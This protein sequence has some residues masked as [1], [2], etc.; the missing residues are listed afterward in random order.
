MLRLFDQ[1]VNI[2]IGPTGGDNP[3]ARFSAAGNKLSRW[4]DGDHDRTV[5]RDPLS[6]QRIGHLGGSHLDPYGA[7]YSVSPL[8]PCLTLRQ[9]M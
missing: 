7:V 4:V 3:G 6:P 2:V 8:A 1:A 9:G 5:G